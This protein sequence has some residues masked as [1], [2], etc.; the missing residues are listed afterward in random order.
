MA[1]DLNIIQQLCLE[2]ESNHLDYKRD[3]YPFVGAA[4]CD[5]A[6][7]LK[8]ILALANAFRTEIAYVLIGVAQTSDGSGNIVGIDP[9]DFIDDA[10]LQNK[11]CNQFFQLF[12]SVPNKKNYSSY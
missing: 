10:K 6:E 3:Q 12:D 2:G 9:T 4:D 8:D 5:K 1:I 7:L 11:S